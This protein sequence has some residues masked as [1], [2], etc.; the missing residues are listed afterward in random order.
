MFKLKAIY[1]V[2]ILILIF[3]LG[4]FSY[5]E[6]SN[7]HKDLD[8][9]LDE[10]SITLVNSIR[11]AVETSINSTNFFDE[12]LEKKMLAFP[13]LIKSAKGKS[14]ATSFDSTTL[15]TEFGINEFYCFSTKGIVLLSNIRSSINK[16]IPVDLLIQ[17]MQNFQ[18]E[19]IELGDIESPFTEDKIFSLVRYFPDT[20][21][22][23]LV[24]ISTNILAEWRRK[25]SFG[26]IIR[27]IGKIPNVQYFALQ[28]SLG[29][30]AFS[31]DVDSLSDFAEDPF[32][33][34]LNNSFRTRQIK[35]KNYTLREIVVRIETDFQENLIARLGVSQENIIHLKSHST[36]RTLL[37][38]FTFFALVLATVY[39][40]FFR[41][42]FR[43]LF[44]KHTQFRYYSE[45][46]FNNSAEAILLF[47]ENFNIILKNNLAEHIF[48]LETKTNYFDIFPNDQMNISSF[49]KIEGNSKYHEISYSTS[50]GEKTFGCTLVFI[51]TEF[52]NLYLL[53]A[54][55]LTEIRELQRQVDANEMFAALG[56]AS[57]TFAHEIRN[58]LNSIS[59]I[60]QRLEL[61]TN[62]DDAHSKLLRLIRKEIERLNEIVTQFTQLAKPE[63]INP[64]KVSVVDIIKRTIQLLSENIKQ[65][66]IRVS[67]NFQD[68][69]TILADKEKLHQAF[70]NIILNSFDAIESDGEI[71]ILTQLSESYLEIIFEDN[72][73]GIPSN[74]IHKVLTPFFT[75]KSKGLGIGLSISQRIIL[76]H[77]GK[78]SI[79]NATEKKGTKVI[80]SLP[81]VN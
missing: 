46:I 76:A 80:V 53:L 52:E 6:I 19:I 66:Q 50:A 21:V 68:D 15:F 8:K 39:L 4:I 55:D 58:P 57:A 59:M 44:T 11:S 32:L 31:G 65:K 63:N 27:E 30:I 51:K 38:S 29:I 33:L 9:I 77:R 79:H 13:F 60:A 81:V 7:S 61:E 42:K 62:L 48:N 64:E 43:N 14:F 49:D 1:S 28:D 20:K 37:A 40:I 17:T 72:G 78:L 2:V 67:T 45:Q 12:L 25:F 75:T 34:N 26:R 56:A 35:Y 22:Y 18:N 3:L 47:D 23:C 70:L 73:P 5:F 16:K 54:I 36:Y 71:N 74:I 69:P 10:E 41:Q 24:G